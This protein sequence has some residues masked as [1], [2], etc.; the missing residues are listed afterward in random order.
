M[1]NTKMTKEQIESELSQFY[2][3]E[4]W[5]KNDLLNFTYTDG[6][7]FIHESCEA[8]W[9]LIAISSYKRTEPFQ[10]WE[11]KVNNNKA[12]LT[13]REDTNKPIKVRQV[14]SFTDFPLDEIKFYLID[15]V[16]LLPSEY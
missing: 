7:K 16:L 11:L 13:M 2:G 3:T 1:N 14:I 6:V 12:V 4:Q 15:N 9:L 10:V 5:W 8:Y